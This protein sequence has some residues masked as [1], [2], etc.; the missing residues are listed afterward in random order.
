M[1]KI[2]VIHTNYQNTGGEDIAVKN[3]VS[4]LK[5]NFRGLAGPASGSP[6]GSVPSSR[7]PR[8][9]R[10]R[11]WH[12]DSRRCLHEFTRRGSPPARPDA[13][14]TH[15]REPYCYGRPGCGFQR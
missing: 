12:D 7:D 3:E 11:H 6:H 14:V 15:A 8:V 2:L 5:K 10:R 4:F 13:S 1:K 9:R